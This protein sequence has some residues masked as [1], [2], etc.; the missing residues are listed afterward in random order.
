MSETRRVFLLGG[1]AALLPWPA[2]AAE[3]LHIGA[4]RGSIDFAIGDSKIFRTTGSFREWQGLVRVDDADVARSTVQVKVNTNSIQM[5]DAQQSEM[6][7]DADFFDVAKFPNMTYVS[8]KVTRTSDS[9]LKVE[10]A[11]TLR[12]TTRPMELAVSVT[13]R[14]PD[15]AAGARYARFRAE[16]SLKRSEFGMVKY[17]DVVGD[18][19]DFSIRTDAWR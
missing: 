2:A 3:Q 13:D 19:V 6:L 15:A 4:A 5:M 11:I 14:K 9:T 10:G 8:S 1:A 7:K 12:G 18:T 16:G 17:I